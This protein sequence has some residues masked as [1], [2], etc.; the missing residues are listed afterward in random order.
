MHADLAA[1]RRD[2]RVF[3]MRIASTE[4]VCTDPM[5]VCAA[6]MARD[7]AWLTDQVPELKSSP[8]ADVISKGFQ[9]VI[10]HDWPVAL[11]WWQTAQQRDPGNEALRRSVDLAQW[12]VDRRRAVTAGT[13]PEPPLSLAIRSAA[14]NDYVGAIR[15]FERAK[16]QH[17]ASAAYLDDM[18]VI[19]RQRQAAADGEHWN[20]L[21]RANQNAIADVLREQAMGH[22]ATGQRDRAQFSFEEAEMFSRP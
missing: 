4:P 3:R 14:R 11:A 15:Q 2:K 12:M 9:A 7:G 21:Y 8:A 16:R 6:G 13:A 5:V 17:P 20:R 19:V 1:S 10:N 18:I 22:L